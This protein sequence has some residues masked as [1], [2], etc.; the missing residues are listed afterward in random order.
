MLT[1]LTL[2]IMSIVILFLILAVREDNMVYAIIS[3]V[4]SSVA[5]LWWSDG[6]EVLRAKF[7]V[8]NAAAETVENMGTWVT[9]TQQYTVH[10]STSYLPV[11]FAFVSII[12]IVYLVLKQFKE[13]VLS[14]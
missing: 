8:E 6:F 3:F 1:V 2:F 13:G 12:V 14:S 4:F 5:T 9:T 7:V 11:L 10:G